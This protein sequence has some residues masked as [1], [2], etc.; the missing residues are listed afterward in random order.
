MQI[1]FGLLQPF[2]K[3][4]GMARMALPFTTA[5]NGKYIPLMRWMSHSRHTPLSYDCFTHISVCFMF[6]PL[7]SLEKAF[8]RNFHL[9]PPSDTLQPR[10][11]AKRWQG[12]P[13][14]GAQR[15]NSSPG[16]R[17]FHMLSASCAMALPF[18][19]LKKGSSNT[20][21]LDKDLH[22]LSRCDRGTFA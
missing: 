3:L 6:F 21:R 10:A 16:L 13:G 14:G 1:T 7:R 4:D 9:G 19:G 18:F 11:S 12:A 15:W 17:W 20:R 8:A 22:R 5:S 2:P